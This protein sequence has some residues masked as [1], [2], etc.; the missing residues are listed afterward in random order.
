MFS[1]FSEEAQ[2]A[3]INAKREMNNLRH[4]YVGSEHF[5]LYFQ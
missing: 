4:P 1:R 3:L 2:K 5:F